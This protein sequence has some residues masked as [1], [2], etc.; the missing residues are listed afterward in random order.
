M[1]TATS[2]PSALRVASGVTA[3]PTLPARASR[4][5]A[6]RMAPVSCRAEARQT[7]GITPADV[8]K[9]IG[10]SAVTLS[11]AAALLCGSVDPAFADAGY[12]L[13]YGTA[14]SA[15]SY[16]GYGGNS[17]KQDSA[18][19]TYEVPDAWKERAISKVE[20]GTNGTDSEF[21]N[22]K[23]RNAKTYLLFL[24]GFRRLPP[25]ENVLNDIALSDVNLQDLIMTADEIKQSQRLDPST[26]QLYYD[27]EIEGPLGHALISVTC[28]KNK[29][30]AH[31]VNANGNLWGKDEATFRHIHDSFKTV[32][33]EPLST[34]SF[35]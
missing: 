29:L 34:G 11:T 28:A 1:A 5:A 9:W 6:V 24:A 21:F 30:Y 12:K 15:S 25:Q 17:S 20:K 33:R 3:S 2:L 14:A 10:T 8:A 13:Y 35:Y 18:E 32:G 23:N 7:G 27:F 4:S 22:P 26:D 16:G 19:Y 31:F